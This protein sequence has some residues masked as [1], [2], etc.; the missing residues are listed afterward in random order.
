RTVPE[1]L[2]CAR[3]ADHQL[4]ERASAQP[5]LPAAARNQSVRLY[6]SALAVAARVSAVH[7]SQFGYQPGLLLVSL[8][9]SPLREAFFGRIPVDGFLDLVEAHGGSVVFERRR[10]H[11]RKS[12]LRSGS[13]APAGRHG[14]L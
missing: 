9:A 5:V 10:S 6:G 4:F 8:D 7:G 11:A 1:Y 13:Y 14:D 12:D 3:S 2:S